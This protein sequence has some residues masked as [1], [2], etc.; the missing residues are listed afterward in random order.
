[1]LLA[2]NM[3]FDKIRGS[4]FAE[5]WIGLCKQLTWQRFLV[6]I[7]IIVIVIISSS[8]IIAVGCYLVQKFLVHES[9]PN[10]DVEFPGLPRDRSIRV[11]T[12]VDQVL[13]YLTDPR[14]EIVPEMNDA[15]ILWTKHYLKDF[16]FV[17]FDIGLITFELT[18]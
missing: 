1:M 8:S 11:Y 10:I 14:F 12:D 6:I 5:F 7:I 2:W 13:Q 4:S 17:K 9:L 16:K 15:D 18:V 3:P